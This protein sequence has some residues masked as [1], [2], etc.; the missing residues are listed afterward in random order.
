MF[1][2]AILIVGSAIDNASFP[3]NGAKNL[4]VGF[5]PDFI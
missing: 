5:A 2:V 4:H 3:G 1:D